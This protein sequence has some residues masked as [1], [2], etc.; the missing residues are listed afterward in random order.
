MVTRYDPRSTQAEFESGSRGRVLRNRLG[1]ARVR[2]MSLAESQALLLAQQQAVEMYSEDHR[3]TAADVC[4]LHRLWL[5]PIYAWA[6]EYRNV[7]IGK[8][9]LQF[10]HAPLVPG[11]MA[12]LQRG[13]LARHTPCRPMPDDELA[14]ALAEVHAELI[15]V[16]PF[17]E[18]NGR[19]ARMIAMLMG[20]Q[21][22]LP[23][24]DFSPLEGRGK[25]RYFAG[26]RAALDRDY[27]PLAE[28][29]SRVIART[30]KCVSSSDPQ[31]IVR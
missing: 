8:G 18:G 25:E 3:F 28:V 12:D 9:G 1:I 2:D 22:G 10:A 4:S 24:L 31:N 29:F 15:L 30:W 16:H 14:M 17:R 6:G 11:L 26:I 21:A 5:G 19:I 13:S 27:A 7:N 20:L 23:P